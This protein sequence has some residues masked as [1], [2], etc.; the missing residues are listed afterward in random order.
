LMVCVLS[1][2]LVVTWPEAKGWFFRLIGY[3]PKPDEAPITEQIKAVEERL[4]SFLTQVVFTE[5]ARLQGQVEQTNNQF[6]KNFSERIATLENDRTKA[7]GERSKLGLRISDV[8]RKGDSSIGDIQGLNL[9]AEEHKAWIRDVELSVV[10]LRP[11]VRGFSRYL[12]RETELTDLI[13]GIRACIAEHQD[14]RAFYPDHPAVTKPF[15]TSWRPSRPEQRADESTKRCD[16]WA[17]HLESH[18]ERVNLFRSKWNVPPVVPEETL[19]GWVTTWW[20]NRHDDG[21]TKLIE[22]MGEH[23]NKLLTMRDGYA[24]DLERAVA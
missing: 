10:A 15:A 12:M 6:R 4:P 21:S 2:I 5:Y 8:E 23:L 14:L 13:H 11:V 16:R 9:R 1:L 3:E 17:R 22:A 19:V 24:A 20:T 7:I 18:I